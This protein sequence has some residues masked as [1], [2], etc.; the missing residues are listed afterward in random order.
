MKIFFWQNIFSI[1][2]AP[3]LKAIDKYDNY[4]ITLLITEKLRQERIEMG[5]NTPNVT[6]LKV[7]DLSESNTSMYQN[8]LKD[9]N[10]RNALHIFSGI[11]A[12]HKVYMALSIAIKLNCRIGIFTEP[13][14]FRGVKGFLRRLRG[15][16]YKF[17]YDKKIEFILT[18]GKIGQTQFLQFGFHPHKVFEW[19]YSVDKSVNKIQANPEIKLKI[20]YAGS[21][22]QRKGFDILL[23]ALEQLQKSNLPFTANL[24]CLKTSQVGL[25]QQIK[26][27]HN[28]NDEISFHE[29]KPNKKLRNIISEHDLFVLPSRHDGWGAVISESLAE[30]TP[31]IASDRCGASTLIN[32]SNG[33]V[34]KRLTR[35]CLHHS[36][37]Q[38][39]KGEKLNVAKRIKIKSDYEKFAS[40]EAL[41]KYF[42]KILVFLNSDEAKK[43]NVPWSNIGNEN[44]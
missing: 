27:K 24:Y 18:T 30:G 32:N 42:E 36:I 5:W 31:V 41:A 15:F 40:G 25:V 1:H 10:S 33:Q 2:Q 28:F 43:P 39:L 14:D 13:Y 38:E 26:K 17:K 4:E 3:F 8:I 21:L 23:Q 34:L 16:Y 37:L 20:M 11:D 12:F 6:G 29:F 9:N 19:A 7:I 35:E 22:I 44:T